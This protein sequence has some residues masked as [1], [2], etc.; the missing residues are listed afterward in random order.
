V[1]PAPRAPRPTSRISRDTPPAPSPG[2][3]KAQA[4]FVVALA[5]SGLS[6]LTYQVVWARQLSLAVGSGLY[7]ITVAV[8]AFFAGLAV[9]SVFLGR[10]ADRVGAP[11]RLYAVVEMTIALTAFAS[12]FFL[13]HADIPFS[14]MQERVGI[15]AWLIPFL[16]VGIPCF[17]MGGTL[18]IAVRA[19]RAEG[20]KAAEEGGLLYTANTGGGIVGAL[21]ASFI[22]IPRFGLRGSAMAA[23]GINLAVGALVYWRAPTS[24]IAVQ[25]SSTSAQTGK[26]KSPLLL[27]IYALA[28]GIALGYEVVWTQAIGQFVSTRAFSFSIVLAVYLSGLASGAWFGTLIV[29][30][31]RDSWGVF[32]L[33]IAGAALVAMLE[34]AFM[35]PWVVNAQFALG[36]AVLSASGS[37][38]ARMYVSFLTAGAGLVFLPTL[39]L[40]AAFPLAL[41]LIV[42]EYRRVGRDVGLVVATNIAGGIVGTMLTG[43]VMI[44][45]LGLVRTLAI[46]TILATAAGAIATLFA[47]SRKNQV[48]A[49]TIAI[50]TLIAAI[51]T[52]ADR[53]ANLLLATRGGGALVF[54][55]E[56]RGATVAVAQQRFKDNVFRRLYIQGVS[57]SG[58]ALPS[59][60]YMR[61][62]AMIPLLI[63]TGEP[64]SVMVIGFGT[65]ITAGETLR[66]PGLEKRVCAELLPAVVRSGQLFPENYKAWNDP[67]MQI[68]IRD[69]RQELL[70]SKEKY[71]VITL[72]PPPPSAQG[73]AN[74]YS[75]EFYDLAKSRLAS[76]GL[77]AQWLPLTTQND[78]ET[79][80]L[81]RT[82][83]D[84]FPYATLWTTE[85]HEMML[86]G[87]DSSIS[88]DARNIEERFAPQSVVASLKAVGIDSPAALLA[89]WVTGR[90]GLE[91]FAA[92]AAPVTDNNP[93]VEYGRWVKPDEV[94][95]VLPATLGLR[96]DIPLDGTDSTLLSEIQ[97]RQQTLTDFYAAGLAAYEGDHRTWEAAIKRVQADDP[98]NAYYSY[99]IGRE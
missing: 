94:T 31:V 62:Q 42:G 69:G 20:E 90:E 17:A 34:F 72:E 45:A 46:L 3:Q 64:K 29:R 60:R 18:P 84:V 9:G 67:R 11:S 79:R 70:Q 4:V 73:V 28:G 26:I 87:S 21:A 12:T 95:R 53:L 68:R 85:L 22:L 75:V 23:A 80:G 82:F 77:F 19:L 33:L 27:W 43:F 24:A 98:E 76:H 92:A 30:K 25:T 47:A 88:L 97:K 38:A 61:L 16:L 55:E 32:G 56:G 40:G 8:A 93:R 49:A 2:Q 5:L 57:N 65:G 10:M 91:K 39:L 50:A 58:D 54:Y 66:Y 6:S 63:H 48:I 35:G 41:R 13:S 14:W 52:P 37:E 81:V 96:S 89:T 78:Q 83:L 99:V 74:L 59:M 7:S 15:M 51:M 36:N 44:P 71:D 86:V 1:K